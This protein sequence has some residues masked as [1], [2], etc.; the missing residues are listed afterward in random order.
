LPAP[1]AGM[2]H[3]VLSQLAERLAAR[4]S[5][6]AADSEA[7]LAAVAA[8]LRVTHEP[9]LL[10]IKRAEV[11]GDPWSGHMAFPGGRHDPG[12]ATL[13]ETAVRETRE[14]TAIDLAQAGR[15]IGRLDDLAPRSPLLPRII[16]RPFVAVV[17]A[18][19][20]VVAS[21]EVAAHYWVPLAALRRPEMQA[22][23]ELLHDGV[24]LRFPGYRVGPHVAWGLTERILRQLLELAHPD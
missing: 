14:E 3:P 7:R 12:D 18:D 20:T 10:F 22:E 5:R 15:L 9:E 11:A 8:V 19:V 2:A 13:A 24:R 6:E 23:H 16:I 4:P 17:R 21:D 1:P